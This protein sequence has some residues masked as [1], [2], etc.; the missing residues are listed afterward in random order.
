MGTNGPPERIGS[1]LTLE[2]WPVKFTAVSV[3]CCLVLAIMMLASGSGLA[4]EASQDTAALA[5]QL[6][7]EGTR[8]QLQGNVD[9]AIEKYKESLA[10]QPN[11]RLQ[12]LVGQLE[13]NAGKDGAKSEAAEAP[14]DVERGKDVQ[15]PPPEPPVDNTP[16]PSPSGDMRSIRSKGQ[17]A[18]ADEAVSNAVTN[19]MTATLSSSVQVETLLSKQSVLERGIQEY[20]SQLSLDTRKYEQGPIRAIEVTEETNEA[21]MYRVLAKID[22]HNQGFKDFL[23][24]LLGSEAGID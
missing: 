17:G 12:G 8:L 14:P 24:N 10:L 7:M 5:K 6:Q 9:K 20:S 13:K 3:V 22:V 4:A 1:S 16:P 19:A 18:T 23:R 11:Q 15:Q 2:L 21:G